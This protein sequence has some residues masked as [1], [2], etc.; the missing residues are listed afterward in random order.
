MLV[1]ELLLLGVTFDRERD[2]AIEERGYGRPLA[3]HIFEYMLIVVKPGMV[4]TSL[5]Y[6]IP[7]SPASRKSTR[8]MPAQSIAL[9]AA[10]ASART[11]SL[12]VSVR[13]RG[14]HRARASSR[15]F[16]S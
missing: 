10:I 11:S 6:S 15:Y 3:S 12:R 9:N 13:R 7:L 14:N 1:R 16:A 4:F 8:A 2:Q 5:R